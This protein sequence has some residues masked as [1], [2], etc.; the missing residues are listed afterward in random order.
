MSSLCELF[1]DFCSGL[2]RSHFVLLILCD[3]YLH[4]PPDNPV[5]NYRSTKNVTA[6]KITVFSGSSHA[7]CDSSATLIRMGEKIFQIPE[8]KVKIFGRGR[9]FLWLS[10]SGWN[11]G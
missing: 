8:P 10:I 6:K 7:E 4:I 11:G 9:R 5:I 1:S 2:Y 3:K